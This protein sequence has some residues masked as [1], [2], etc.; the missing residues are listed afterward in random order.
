[1]NPCP[2]QQ[3]TPGAV[4]VNS[5]GP[6][7][8]P[9]PASFRG[10]PR[11]R[12]G[13]SPPSGQPGHVFDDLVA[14]LRGPGRG[15]RARHRGSSFADEVDPPRMRVPSTDSR[16]TPDGLRSSQKPADAPPPPSAGTRRPPGGPGLITRYAYVHVPR[17]PLTPADAAPPESE[18][19]WKPSWPN[20]NAC[21]GPGRPAHGKPRRS[22]RGRRPR[23]PR[24]NIPT[25]AERWPA[26]ASSRPRTSTPPSSSPKN[27]HTS[28]CPEVVEIE[29]H[30]AQAIPGM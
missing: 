21:G 9:M 10:G 29:V 28:T 14:C 25:A 20:G 4:R 5:T 8:S 3:S 23:H 18:Q 15:R 6:G 26:T 22:T 7:G 16:P 30:E 12:A 27:L 13:A 19:E 17:G 2:W 24:P 1:M 11:W